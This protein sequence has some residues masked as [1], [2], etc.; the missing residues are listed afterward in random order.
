MHL[1]KAHPEL[2]HKEIVLRIIGHYDS[3]HHFLMNYPEETIK[4]CLPKWEE[5][6]IQVPSKKVKISKDGIRVR[7]SLK[8]ETIFECDGKKVP[9]LQK[10]AEC[11]LEKRKIQFGPNCQRKFHSDEAPFCVKEKFPE[12][13]PLEQLFCEKPNAMSLLN[14]Q[15]SLNAQSFSSK[16][17]FTI[18][19]DKF[20]Y[21]C[22]SRNNFHL[23]KKRVGYTD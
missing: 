22:F 18:W 13:L 1:S 5:H 9:D 8:G 12:D 3:R 16:I 11:S 20:T 15:R 17:W 6:K 23:L 2:Q 7:Y 4:L 14:F 19:K 10:L 21:E